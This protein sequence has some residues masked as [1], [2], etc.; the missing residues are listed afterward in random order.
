MAREQ[1]ENMFEKKDPNREM[2]EDRSPDF[3]DDF[4][5]NDSLNANDEG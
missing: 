4:E 1:G 3:E 2:P 5:D